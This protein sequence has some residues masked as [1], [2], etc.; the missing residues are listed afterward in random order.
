MRELEFGDVPLQPRP[1]GYPVPLTAWQRRVWNAMMKRGTRLSDWRVLGASA[2]VSGPLNVDLLRNSIETVVRRHESLRSRIVFVDDVPTQQVDEAPEYELE[3]IDLARTPSTNVKAQAARVIQDFAHASRDLSV[4]PLFD[5]KL[6]RLSSQKHLL[7]LA[8]DHMLS[9][10]VSSKILG[11]EIW[12]AYN[13][14]ALGR[15]VSLPQLPVQFADYAVW[16]QLTYDAW[17]KR[18]GAHW[19]ERLTGA[20][21][22]Q[23]PLDG[24]LTDGEDGS[25]SIRY[26]PLGKALSVKLRELARRERTL[27][28]LAALT[29]YAS[30]VSHWSNQRDL[31]LTFVAHGR[32]SHPELKNMIGLLANLLPFRLEINE[33]DSFIDLLE[34]IKL[35]FYNAHRH[36]DYNR[37]PDIVA[38]YPTEFCFNWVPNWTPAHQEIKVDSQIEV[39][40]FPLRASRGRV[41][42]W[43]TFTAALRDTPSGLNLSVWHRENFFAPS[44]I[45]RFA[46][47]FRLLVEEFIQRPHTSIGAIDFF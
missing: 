10:G 40:P 23:L 12:T 25:L 33:K 24:S 14:A 36:Q 8:M 20:P 29:V 47:H 27:L 2:G 13:Q 34:R 17:L 35:E 21:H 30:A 45:E 22:I 4:G 44:T 31:V 46:H 32:H 42:A 38:D 41:D 15:E 26:F 19:K 39:Q 11:K 37:V 28:S 18:H 9:D 7:L 6:V 5:A 16:Q 43:F 1:A 3:I